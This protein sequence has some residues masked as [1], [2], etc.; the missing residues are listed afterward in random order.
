MVSPLRTDTN[1]ETFSLLYRMKVAFLVCV[2]LCLVLS[3][4]AQRNYFFKT[5]S[6]PAFVGERDR[7]EVPPRSTRTVIYSIDTPLFRDEYFT[8]FDAL[9]SFD[10][11]DTV[12]PIGWAGPTPNF[13]TEDAGAGTQITAAL[14]L[15]MGAV[16]LLI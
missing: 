8:D 6:S 13:K 11:E 7:L 10:D 3:A 16:A 9:N 14:A 1:N 4:Q 12:P 2:L 15:L 5:L